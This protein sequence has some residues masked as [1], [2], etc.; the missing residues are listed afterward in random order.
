MT[1]RTLGVVG[2]AGIAASLV[3]AATTALS[4]PQNTIPSGAK[5]LGTAPIAT[6]HGITSTK[7]AKGDEP[8]NDCAAVQRAN[9]Y[10]IQAP[11]RGALVARLVARGELDAAIA[12]YRVVRSQRTPVACASTNRQGRARV[13]W[14][15]YS[16][17]SYL[18]GVAARTSSAGGEYDLDVAV[19][20]PAPRPPGASLPV[21]GT[22]D[23]INS[24]LDNADAYAIPMERGVTYRINVATRA[25]CL[26]VEVY[27]PRTYAFHPAKAVQS[28]RCAGYALFTPGIDGGGTYSVVVRD[29][30][31]EPLWH[32]YRVEV[33]PAA[34]DDMAPGLKLTNGQFV[35]GSIFG[36]G[37]D[38]V[39]LYRFTVPRDNELTTLDLRQKATVGLDL[40]LLNETGSRVACA[41]SGK[42]RQVLREHIAP[43]RYYAAVRSRAK[44]SGAYGLQLF[45]RDVTTTSVLANGTTFAEVPPGVAVPISVNVTSASHGGPVRIEV[46]R[47]DPLTRWHFAD[48]ISGTVS[49][50]GQFVAQW[51]PPSV[52][53]WRAR[54]R[55]VGTPF[56]SF[57]ESGYV[58][59][60]VAEPLE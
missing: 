32:F 52:G 44:S 11:H 12:V 48:V 56:S 5:V 8:S 29:Q 49:A 6:I 35:N 37:I 36:R 42:G 10:V 2:A 22:A 4:T 21:G 53:H 33:A 58:R 57:S 24:V 59:I 50:D 47:F 51:T 19:A 45:V 31:A 13:A 40:L 30:D 55:F 15:G 23:T 1:A 18:I 27:R 7:S 54:A 41:C 43:G 39:D 14:Y 25:R 16:Q 38:T 3:I 20:D 26:T 17:G 28:W 34:A 60:H 9:W 46:D